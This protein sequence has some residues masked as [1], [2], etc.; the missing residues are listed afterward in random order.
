MLHLLLACAPAVVD[1]S[2]S[3]SADTGASA[4]GMPEGTFQGQDADD[5]FGTALAWDGR[6]LHISAPGAQKLYTIQGDQ[7]PEPSDL[8]LGE[9]YALAAHEGSLVVSAALTSGA[10]DRAL[11]S[12]EQGL[13]RLVDQDLWI[14]D[15]S[16][17]LP[18]WGSSLTWWQGEP[19]VGL[20]TGD[21]AVWTPSLSLERADPLDRA[22][23]AVVACDVDGDGLE[24]LAVGA[25][26]AGQVHLYETLEQPPLSM[27][28]ADEGFGS[29]LACGAQGLFIG[30][31]FAEDFAGAVYLY[32]EG[33]LTQIDVGVGL[34]G[35]SLLAVDG[36]LFVGAPGA[37]A[38]QAGRV[39]RLY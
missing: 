20:A 37:R 35:S 16:T 26:G 24:E 36:A 6:A 3:D 17:P 14:A 7:E 9:G 32:A 27:G 34:F 23:A 12:T 29:A 22:G 33:Q 8:A 5:Q 11:L 2:D 10:P 19:A 18:G 38:E 1:F 31:P 4:P 15:T 39:E 25:P 13:A 30:A 28:P 21:T